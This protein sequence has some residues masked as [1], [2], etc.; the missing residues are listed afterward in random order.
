MSQAAS[1]AAG[2]MGQAVAGAASKAS[3]AATKANSAVNEAATGKGRDSV[4]KRG[5]K[6]DPEL[7][8]RLIM[9]QSSFRIVL[10]NVDTR[11]CSL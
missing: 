6:R 2:K 1:R 7:Y 11:Y 8:V 3:G 9:G 10:A 4:L 5:A